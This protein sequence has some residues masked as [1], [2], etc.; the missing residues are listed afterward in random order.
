MAVIE[1][2][3]QFE[4]RKSDHLRL[5]L[6]SKN[7]TGDLSDFDSIELK[8]EALP[9]LNFDTKIPLNFDTLFGFRKPFLVSS[10][11]AGHVASVD[12]NL[13]LARACE[14][15]GWLMGVGSQRRELFDESASEEWTRLRKRCPKVELLGNL[16]ITQLIQTP[17]ERVARLIDS[18]QAKALIVHTNPLQEVLQEEGT[19]QFRGCLNVIEKLCKELEVPVVLKETGCG[20]SQDTLQRL[21]GL[22]LA[23]VDVSGLGGTHW[24]RIEGGRAESQHLKMAAKTFAHWGIGTVQSLVNATNILQRDYRVWASGGM[25]SG[26]DALKA[27]CL[28]AEVSGFAKPV[29][30]AALI[31]E[32]AVV[33][34]MFQIEFEV[35]AGLF[36]VGVDQLSHLSSRE[37]IQWRK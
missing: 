21:N 14:E 27:F 16:G 7:Q 10:M 6:D 8:H 11:T 33:E 17:V 13:R 22:G 25:R 23:A 31:S 2:V 20:F 36:L 28:G 18:M 12:F 35:R 9:E 34:W 32:D 19:P 29:L 37:V 4:K 24:G 30:E 5:S 26:L 1:P 15:M 3:D